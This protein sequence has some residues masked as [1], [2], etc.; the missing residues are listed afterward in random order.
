MPL[1][2]SAQRLTSRRII[3]AFVLFCSIGL[4]ASPFSLRSQA[5]LSA[6]NNVNVSQR[7][8]GEKNLKSA[9]GEPGLAS[10]ARPLFYSLKSRRLFELPLD[11]GFTGLNAKLWFPQSATAAS[12]PSISSISPSSPTASGSNQNITVFGSGFQ[13][14]LTVTVTFPSGGSATLSGTQIQS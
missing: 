14:G 12:T 9:V 10:T 6:L 8:V 5:T 4:I 2:R 11:A 1:V 7:S 3:L 13:A